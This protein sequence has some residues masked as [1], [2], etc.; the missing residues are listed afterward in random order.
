MSK[1]IIYSQCIFISV[2]LLSCGNLS[3]SNTGFTS[4]TDEHREY[5]VDY[6]QAVVDFDKLDVMKKE[7]FQVLSRKS[8]KLILQFSSALGNQVYTEV[9]F[10]GNLKDIQSN[11]IS[12]TKGKEAIKAFFDNKPIS[13]IA[14]IIIKG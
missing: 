4:E 9:L 3:V 12:K 11:T 7:S 1:F 2:L 13:D 14:Q 6:K 5:D 8:D 10:E